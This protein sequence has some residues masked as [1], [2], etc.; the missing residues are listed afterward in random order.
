MT[1]IITDIGA[2]ELANRLLREHNL[3]TW[4]FDIN[5]RAKRRLGCCKYRYKTIELSSWVL[6]LCP[7][8]AENTIRHEVAHA[9]VGPGYGHGQI[10]KRA[11]IKLGARPETCTSVAPEQMAPHK[12]FLVCPGCGWK[13]Y[14]SYR[15]RSR[16]YRSRC[17]KMTFMNKRA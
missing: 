13:G 9:L 10:W 6:E 5:Y 3:N 15:K 14:G 8:K 12:W 4:S 2:Y 11:A 1:Q 17:C 7:E 16:G